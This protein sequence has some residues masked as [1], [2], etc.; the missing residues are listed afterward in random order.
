MN[1][2]LSDEAKKRIE[3]RNRTRGK[4][5]AVCGILAVIGITIVRVIS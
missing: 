5:C 4:I 1:F 3:K 2:T